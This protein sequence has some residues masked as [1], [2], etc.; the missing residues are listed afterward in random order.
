M[1][2]CDFRAVFESECHC[3]I[4]VDRYLVDYSKPQFFVELGYGKRSALNVFD[5]AFDDFA[6]AADEPSAGGR[7]LRFTGIMRSLSFIL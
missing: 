4:L 7:P 1:L 2:S 6:L 5:E 3:A